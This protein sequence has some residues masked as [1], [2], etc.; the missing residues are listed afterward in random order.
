MGQ[1]QSIKLIGVRE[2]HQV[3]AHEAVDLHAQLA[4]GIGLRNGGNVDAIVYVDLGLEVVRAGLDDGD[5]LHV[6]RRLQN[7]LHVG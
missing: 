4:Q 2:L 7:V 6:G 5:H 1:C 3:A